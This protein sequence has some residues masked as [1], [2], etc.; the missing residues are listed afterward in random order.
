LK[1]VAALGRDDA[2]GTRRAPVWSSPTLRTRSRDSPVASRDRFPGKARAASTAISGPL[3]HPARHLD[4]P[5]NQE[6]CR[7]G[8]APSRCSL[9][10]RCP[11]PTTTPSFTPM[12]HPYGQA[13]VITVT[14]NAAAGA[15]RIVTD[16]Q[17]CLLADPGLLRVDLISNHANY[18]LDRGGTRGHGAS[19]PRR[20]PPARWLQPPG[21]RPVGV[22]GPYIGRKSACESARTRLPPYGKRRGGSLDILGGRSADVECQ[23]RRPFPLARCVQ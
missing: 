12:C 9:S 21:G 13:V 17:K 4:Q 14:R 5:V 23:Q 19:S 22:V 11:G 2:V 15:T 10:R 16:A 18:P 7:P 6:V 20:S 8:P 3:E 1:F